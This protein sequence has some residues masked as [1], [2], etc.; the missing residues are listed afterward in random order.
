ML[1][2]YFFRG[3]GGSFTS[4]GV[5]NLAAYAKQVKGVRFAHV[6]NWDQHPAAIENISILSKEKGEKF[7]L[8]GFSLGGNAC[9]WVADRL[10]K[11]SFEHLIALDP[12]I[13]TTNSPLKSNVKK[14]LVFHNRNWLNIF[15]LATLYPGSGFKA[16]NLETINIWDFHLA[17]SLNKKYQDRV[18]KEIT[19][20]AK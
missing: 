16:S 15:G 12:T 20:A 8:F 11:V 7:F 10:P 9:T 5:D 18:L 17:A 6:Y 14:A 13:W 1:C 4:P 2:C 3:Q 19:E